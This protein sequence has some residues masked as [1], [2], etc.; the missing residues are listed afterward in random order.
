[1]YKF[2]EKYDNRDKEGYWILPYH[3]TH[4]YKQCSLCGKIGYHIL[5]PFCPTCGA[6]MDMGYLIEKKDEVEE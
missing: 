5:Y 3:D 2:P 1:M 6:K 4:G